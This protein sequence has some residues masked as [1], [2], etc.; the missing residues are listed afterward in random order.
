LQRGLGNTVNHL[1][2]KYHNTLLLVFG[3]VIGYFILTQP[4]IIAVIQASGE[5]SYVGGG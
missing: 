2:I 5:L 3:A 4:R 1:R